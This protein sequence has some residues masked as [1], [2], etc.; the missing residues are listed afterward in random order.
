MLVSCQQLSFVQCCV[1]VTKRL[2]IHSRSLLNINFMQPTIQYKQ[3][4]HV[5]TIVSVLIVIVVVPNIGSYR[6]S[7]EPAAVCSEW[8][9]TFGVG[10][11][12]LWPHN[13]CAKGAALS[14]GS[15]S[16]G[17]QDGHSG[18][19]VTVRH[20]SSLPNRRLSAG[21]RRK[22]SSAAFRQLKDIVSSDGC[23]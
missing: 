7:D 15:A 18:L 12:T 14:S 10:R 5:C 19:L 11:W 13:A 23:R 3:P 9:C 8:C 20:G 1:T 22:S 16:G 6:R 4:K 2:T 17:F 21:P